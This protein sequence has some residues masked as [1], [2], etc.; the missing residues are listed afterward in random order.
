MFL[1]CQIN[2]SVLET[3]VCSDHRTGILCSNCFSVY[4]SNY[5][6]N[7]HECKKSNCRWGWLLYIVSEIIPVTLFFI[8]VMVLSINFTEGAINGVVLFIRHNAHNRKWLYILPT[9]CKYWIR[10]I[11][12]FHKNLQPKFLCN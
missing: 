12:V 2:I 10:S 1:N 3:L 8:V 5:H 4:A 9:A 6:S 7:T 11:Q